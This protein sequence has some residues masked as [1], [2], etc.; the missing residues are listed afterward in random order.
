[1][2]R[3]NVSYADGEVTVRQY[4]TSRRRSKRHHTTL[5]EV[6]LPAAMIR[7]L[8]DAL[9]DIADDL[10]GG[11]TTIAPRSLNITTTKENA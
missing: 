10:E 8:S 4:R 5:G 9:H 6:A 11:R 1:M 3:L 2:I 7:Q